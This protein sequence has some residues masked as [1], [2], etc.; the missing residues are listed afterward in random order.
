L[1]SLVH[2]EIL[3]LLLLGFRFVPLLNL[4]DINLELGLFATNTLGEL[5]DSWVCDGNSFGECIVPSLD[6]IVSSSKTR[7]YSIMDIPQLD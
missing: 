6:R 1:N 5:A 2:E 7:T 3:L 4:S